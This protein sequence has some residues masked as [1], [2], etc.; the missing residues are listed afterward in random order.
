MLD[1][2]G[3]GLYAID[4]HPAE[5]ET[6][7]PPEAARP[8]QIPLGALIPI[9]LVN[10][11]PACKNI[12]ATHITNGAYRLHPVEWNIGESAGLLAAFALEQGILPRHVL[13]EPRLTRQFQLRL[14]GEGVPL[15]WRIDTPM[16]DPGFEAVQLLATWGVWP[17]APDD[18]HFRPDEPALPVE[19]QRE[20]GP[21]AGLLPDLASGTTRR[22]AAC[23][24]YERMRPDYA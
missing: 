22:E 12:G 23:L 7:L 6:R 24:L 17:G 2:V 16:G 13:E 18:L 1:S 9:R 3:V 19:L 21:A 10:L 15:Y 8:F 5:G 11:L 20:L 4:I 14:T